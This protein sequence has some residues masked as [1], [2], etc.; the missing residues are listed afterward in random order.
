MDRKAF[1]EHVKK[2]VR[3]IPSGKTMTY[4]E[5]ATAAGSPKASRRVGTIM[6]GNFDDSI[7]YHRAIRS[8]GSVGE[9]NRGGAK[10]KKEILQKEKTDIPR[11]Y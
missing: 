4:K 9:Y 3:K 5:V 8:D 11:T 2:I 1:T 10:R 6:K 7:P